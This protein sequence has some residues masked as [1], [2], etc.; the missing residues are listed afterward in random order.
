MPIRRLYEP[1]GMKHLAVKPNGIA[2]PV[3][4]A[5]LRV[6]AARDV[7]GAGVA[8]SCYSALLTPDQI[9]TLRLPGE[10]DAK[11]AQEAGE[12]L[13]SWFAS[14]PPLPESP[15]W[16]YF[17]LGVDVAGLGAALLTAEKK[18]PVEIAARCLELAEQLRTTLAPQWF[19]V[20]GL[21]AKTALGVRCVW[22]TCKTIPAMNGSLAALQAGSLSNSA[23]E[24]QAAWEKVI[25]A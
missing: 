3:D 19:P 11:Q 6:I 18:D 25:R 12:L 24:I 7:A 15:V 13:L 1:P 23:H 5:G 4:A 8:P 2:R 9:R 16:S 10:G 20:F 22:A 21:A 17:G 14:L